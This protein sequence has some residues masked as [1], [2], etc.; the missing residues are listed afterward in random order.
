[1]SLWFVMLS[2]GPAGAQA[3]NDPYS[4]WSVAGWGARWVDSDLPDLPGKL[5]KGVLEVDDA[6]AA[7]LALD[8]RAIPDIGMPWP[9]REPGRDGLALELEAQIVR[10]YGLQDHFE[11]T[12]AL[13]LRT[14]D[15]RPFGGAGV[16]LAWGNGMSW[17]FDHPAW[18][19]GVTGQRGVETRRLQ[20]HMTVEMEFG[21][22]S[23]PVRPFLR[24]H[25]R[26]GIYGVISPQETGSNFIGLGLRVGLD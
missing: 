3:G 12:G 6:W 1:M 22:G 18:E 24:L 7:G 4:R 23:W 17:A 15:W 11:G 10:H 20:Y 16:N 26:S 9:G 19:K 21:R 8:W 14:P 13:V 5:V 2:A 25:H